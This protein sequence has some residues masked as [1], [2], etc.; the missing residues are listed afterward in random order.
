MYLHNNRCCYY[1]RQYKIRHR[2]HF[3]K[4]YETLRHE[5]QN[6][7]N[8]KLHPILT[9]HR[10]ILNKLNLPSVLRCDISIRCCYLYP[11]EISLENLYKPLLER[12]TKS[13][14]RYPT[15]WN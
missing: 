12:R 2:L 11:N 7:C 10:T 5:N 8:K 1:R 13:T 9:H 4:G 14:E 15:G 3:D 6:R